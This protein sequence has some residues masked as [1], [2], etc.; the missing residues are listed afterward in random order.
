MA[1][2]HFSFL[3]GSLTM[4]FIP[5]IVPATALLIAEPVSPPIVLAASIAPFAAAEAASSADRP[6]SLDASR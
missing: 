6:I 2:N 1:Y 4:I 5:L 3:K